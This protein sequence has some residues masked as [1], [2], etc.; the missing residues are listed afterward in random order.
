MAII[1]IRGTS[2]SGKSTLVRRIL[3]HYPTKEPIHVPKRKRPL[4][5]IHFGPGLDPLVTV[6]HYETACGGCDTIT[7][8]KDAFAIVEMMSI[9]EGYDVLFEG[10]LIAADVNRTVDIYRKANE[11]DIGLAVIALTTPI[12]L[13]LSSVNERR[14]AKDPD[15]PPVNPKN[16]QSKYRGVEL[17]IPRLRK[18][19]VAVH[20]CDRQAAYF[21]IAK[22]LNL[23]EP[24]LTLL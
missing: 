24:S 8:V 16:T 17:S 15:K 20:E 14:W 22:L 1:N 3:E 21:T 2:G 23:P 7:D 18:E 10:L 12:D 6:G 5:D 13:C 11:A 4:M 19:G 9:F